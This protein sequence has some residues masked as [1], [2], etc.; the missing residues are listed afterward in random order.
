LTHYKA[1]IG[2]NIQE[3][4]EKLTGACRSEDAQYIKSIL[5]DYQAS[6][7]S[8]I[9]ANRVKGAVLKQIEDII[10]NFNDNFDQDK[11]REAFSD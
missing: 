2:R 8:A 9:F 11:I 1:D 6:Q 3:N 4:E 5:L 10:K 7:E